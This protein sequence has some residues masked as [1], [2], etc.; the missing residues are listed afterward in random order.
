[1]AGTTGGALGVGGAATGGSTGSGGGSTGG[2]IGNGGATTTCQPILNQANLD[3][4]FENCD[5]GS[6][7]RRAAVQC[8]EEKMIT[9]GP[10]A[11]N[12]NCKEDAD[13]NQQPNGYCGEAHNLA[14]YCGCYY[15]CRQDSDCGAGSICE[16]GVVVGRC[17]SAT[18]KTNA[19]CGAGYGCVGTITGTAGT[20]C[21]TT[22]PPLAPIYVCQKAGDLC[23][24]DKDCPNGGGATQARCL[25]DGDHLACGL[26]C[27]PTP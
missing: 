15:G 11:S 4:G 5:D 3:T 14:G 26:V 25:Y 1:V 12:P 27:L 8:P 22:F 21:N 13:C 17:I 19:D 9:P 7:R 20:T 18:C 24:G 16:C 6:K 2:A 10:C 23:S